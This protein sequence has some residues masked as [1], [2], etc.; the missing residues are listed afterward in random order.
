MQGNN[1]PTSKGIDH[2]PPTMGIGMGD[3]S[4]DHNHATIPTATTTAAVSEDTHCT[5]HPATAAAC[6]N[7]Q[8]VDASITT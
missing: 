6:T 5:P 4:T 1:I 2:T 7:L 3:I 8:P